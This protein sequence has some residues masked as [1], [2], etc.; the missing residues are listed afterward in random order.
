MKIYPR[1]PVPGK[2]IKI[3]LYS[4]KDVVVSYNYRFQ[5]SGF[6]YDLLNYID[7]EYGQIL[8][9]RGFGRERFKYFV[10]SDMFF[11]DAVSHKDGL[12]V[13][14]AS[15]A[16]FYVATLLEPIYRSIRNVFLKKNMICLGDALFYLESIE[17]EPLVSFTDR[18]YFR[19]IS[20]I[21]VRVPFQKEGKLSYRYIF[22]HTD[23]DLFEE[24]LTLNLK[25]KIKVGMK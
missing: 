7:K 9:D 5:I 18:V 6:L 21:S 4:P 12:H 17:E 16:E 11:S 24:R 2:R 19:A 20:P 8:H 23:P 25:K 13:K 1:T 3:K 22:P 14:A 10:F 15:S